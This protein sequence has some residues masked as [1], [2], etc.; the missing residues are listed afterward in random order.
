MTDNTRRA[1]ET[2]RDTLL[3]GRPCRDAITTIDLRN[4]AIANLTNVVLE[5]QNEIDALREKIEPKPTPEPW[6]EP[7]QHEPVP[8]ADGGRTRWP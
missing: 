1:L 8:G 4:I 2:L 3:E 6:P 5:Q 7:P